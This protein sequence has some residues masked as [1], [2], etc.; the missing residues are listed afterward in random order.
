MSCTCT[1]AWL[2]SL[3]RVQTM[4]LAGLI[5]AGLCAEL[6]QGASLADPLDLVDMFSLSY[7]TNLPTWFA[8]SQLLVC[9]LAIGAVAIAT[10]Q[11]SGR[12]VAHWWGL[13]AALL[14][15]SLDETVQLHE[16]MNHWFSTGGVLYFGWVIPAS[17]IVA[18]FVVS[19]LGFLG[20]LPKRTR[21]RFVLA[22]AIFVGGA[23]G[24]EFGLGYWADL[25]G[26]ENLVY[27]LIDWVEESM[28]ICGIGEDAPSSLMQMSVIHSS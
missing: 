15:I 19:Y 3:R 23:L 1:R 12:Y 27:G 10:R 8:S 4:C 11:A 14:Y 5:Y 21:N 6:W 17:V 22:G 24:V 13:A 9:S 16:Q 18:L 28:E 7:E 20:H 2:G 26:D 25:E